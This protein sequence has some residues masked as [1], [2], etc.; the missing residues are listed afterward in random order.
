MT[1]QASL[2]VGDIV[3]HRIH[4]KVEV[5]VGVGRN[6]FLCTYRKNILAD[7]KLRPGSCVT[8]HSQKRLQRIG[9]LDKVAPISL[10]K[11]HD[12]EVGRVRQK[13]MRNLRR[14]LA[15]YVTAIAVS[16]LVIFGAEKIYSGFE[17][18]FGD[19]FLAK[20][21]EEAIKMIVR[22]RERS[23]QKGEQQGEEGIEDEEIRKELRR[24]KNQM[25][26]SD[27]EIERLKAQYIREGVSTEELIRLG[28]R[29]LKSGVSDWQ[30]ERLKKK[31]LKPGVNMGR[32]RK[33][34]ERFFGR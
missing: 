2:A 19:D 3:K 26:I 9:H 22:E 13:R 17:E 15:F 10:F 34:K 11:L 5:I 16:V 14:E 23:G 6:R 1:E 8:L 29:Y 28:K 32:L 7:G 20:V 24:L 12:E 25:G 4:G 33:L 27:E 31:Y 21:G 30:R 18:D